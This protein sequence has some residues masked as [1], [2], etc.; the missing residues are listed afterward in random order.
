MIKKLILAAVLALIAFSIYLYNYLGAYK[1]V[2]FAV[3]E[4]GPMYLLSQT[5]TGAYHL[6]GAKI[7]EVEKWAQDHGIPCRKTFG[8]YLDDPAGTDQDRLHSRGGCV[9]EQKPSVALPEGYEF[10]ERAKRHY[11]V[12]TYD[13]SPA[14]GPF[15]VYPKAKEY[16][17]T[18]RLKSDGPVMEIYTINGDSVVTRYHFPI[19][20]PAGP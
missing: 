13:G 8:E 1:S 4:A 9:L 10:E 2:T 11:V 15:T 20:P 5:H 19:A 18:Q 3:E 12:A 16:L 7:S 14:I 6:I 17:E